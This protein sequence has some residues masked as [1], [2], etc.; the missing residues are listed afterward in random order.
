MDTQ[1]TCED[2]GRDGSEVDTNQAMPKISRKQ[3][4]LK[5]DKEGFFSRAFRRNQPC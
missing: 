4:K 1:R 2:R 3:Q 5:R